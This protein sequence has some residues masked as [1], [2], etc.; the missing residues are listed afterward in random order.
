MKTKFFKV[1]LFGA[2]AVFV[3]VVFMMLNNKENNFWD[4]S[5]YYY[6]GKTA[7]MNQDAYDVKVLKA[8]MEADGR[9]Y[10]IMQP[11]VYSPVFLKIFKNLS[12]VPFYVLLYIFIGI[13]FLALAALLWIWLSLLKENKTPFMPWI[14]LIGFGSPVLIDFLTGNVSVFEQL[15]IWSGILLYLNNKIKTGMAFMIAAG[16]VKTVLLFIPCA[17]IFLYHRKDF[18][19]FASVIISAAAIAAFNYFT[20]PFSLFEGSALNAPAYLLINGVVSKVIQESVI[21]PG[22]ILYILFSLVILLLWI[23]SFIRENKEDAIMSLVLAY[24]LIAPRFS[25]Y[26]FIIAAIPVIYFSF[27]FRYPLLMLIPASIPSLVYGFRMNVFFMYIPFIITLIVFVL[28]T[29]P[30]A[31]KTYKNN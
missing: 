30:K 20:I 21:N 14:V 4:F 24:S 9:S 11:F 3:V 8:V 15:F 7:A 22:L 10:G 23:I 26:S 1:S 18:I 31:I 2:L 13:K 19:L 28:I 16:S 27:K 29:V 5:S 6:A 12:V 25:D 17:V